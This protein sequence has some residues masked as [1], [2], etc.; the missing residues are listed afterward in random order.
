M[1]SLLSC[2]IITTDTIQWRAVIP[3]VVRGDMRDA[4]LLL[5]AVSD[6]DVERYGGCL[7]VINRCSY[8]FRA[9]VAHGSDG[10]EICLFD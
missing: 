6:G 7:I 1:L 4:D 5:V 10:S 8:F 2:L 9:S 3:L